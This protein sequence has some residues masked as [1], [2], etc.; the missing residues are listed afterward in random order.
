MK[1]G[2]VVLLMVVGVV[3]P[4]VARGQ[5]SVYAEF[6]AGNFQGGPQ[7]NYLYGGQGGLLLD[8]P[9]IFHLLQVSADIQGRFLN[10]NGEAFNGVVVGPRFSLVPHFFKL[11][12]FAEFNFGFARYNDG[13]NN[14][15][16]DNLFGAQAGVTRQ[17]TSHVDAIVDYS[18]ARYGY[19]SGFYQPQSYSAGAVYRFAKR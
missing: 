7:G 4:K 3:S 10:K 9:K 5:A 16:T 6:T 19:N 18:Y 17:I 13:A 12:P 15:T 1:Y 11:S 2:W 14:S 8:G